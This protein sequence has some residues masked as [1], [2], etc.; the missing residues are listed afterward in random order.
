MWYSYLTPLTILKWDLLK[1]LPPNFYITGIISLMLQCSF[2]VFTYPDTYMYIFNNNQWPTLQRF[3]YSSWIMLGCTNSCY[4]G[5][6]EAFT[7]SVW[8]I[9]LYNICITMFVSVTGHQHGTNYDIILRI[10]HSILETQMRANV[11]L[12]GGWVA[13]VMAGKNQTAI[14]VKM[15]THS[16]SP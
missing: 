10:N 16:F 9:C 4:R 11:V 6:I 5:L 12:M 7:T 8:F 13:F 2:N 3:S 1:V 14:W 15:S